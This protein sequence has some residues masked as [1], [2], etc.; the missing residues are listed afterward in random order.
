MNEC[1][2]AMINERTQTTKFASWPRTEP[3]LRYTEPGL[4]EKEKRERRGGEATWPR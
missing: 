3:S 4:M 2:D 1:G